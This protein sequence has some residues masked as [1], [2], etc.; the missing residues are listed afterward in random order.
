MVINC[1]GGSSLLTISVPQLEMQELVPLAPVP[2]APVG[3]SVTVQKR[4]SIPHCPQTLQQTL[5]GQG[6]ISSNS[7]PSSGLSVP[8][9]WGPQMALSIIAGIGGSPSL[10]QIFCWDWRR[11]HP[12]Q[13]HV[14]LLNSSISSSVML[15]A[16]ANLEQ[17]SSF[18]TR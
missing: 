12:I 11:S 18:C 4:S 3:D 17:D 7:V 15:L 16:L 13:P 6:F 10:R 8:G 9:F 5:R 14:F 1:S 2:G